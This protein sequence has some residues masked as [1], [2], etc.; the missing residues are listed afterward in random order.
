MDRGKNV[1]TDIDPVDG[2]AAAVVN[3]PAQ[4]AQAS[5]PELIDPAASMGDTAS[6]KVK[7]RTTSEVWKYFIRFRE[8]GKEIAS[9]KGCGKVYAVG[10]KDYGT[11]TLRRHTVVCANLKKYIDVGVMML[12]HEGNLRRRQIDHN[13]VWGE[14]AAAIMKHGLPYSFV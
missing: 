4:T 11:S 13:T 7:R 3:Q 14:F 5:Q 12:D 6:T 10:S 9:C 1:V 2:T 8:E